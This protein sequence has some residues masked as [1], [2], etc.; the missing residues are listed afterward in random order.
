MERQLQLSL[1]LSSIFLTVLSI[2]HYFHYPHALPIT[3]LSTVSF[4]RDISLTAMTEAKTG[5]DKAGA[6]SLCQ[7]SAHSLG[8][9][10]RCDPSRGRCEAGNPLS[11]QREFCTCSPKTCIRQPEL[12]GVG[13]EKS[14][15]GTCVARQYSGG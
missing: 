14:N 15:P 3:L 6:T 10:S 8:P 9:C 1:S 11:I 12:G 7:G 4:Q 13:R 2:K 5:G